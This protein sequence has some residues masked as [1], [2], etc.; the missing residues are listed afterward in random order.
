EQETQEY[1]PDRDVA[2]ET[3]QDHGAG[4][5]MPQEDSPVQREYGTEPETQTDPATDPYGA[6]TDPMEESDPQ[7]ASTYGEEV[8]TDL[9]EM[10][11]EELSGRTVTTV[12]GEE[13][14]EIGEI[15]YSATH[16]ERVATVEVGGFLGV[17]GKRIAIPLSELEPGEDDTSV[18]TSL[19]RESIEAQEEFD[20]AGFTLDE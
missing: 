6:E 9:S 5:E 1:D 8:G 4:M 2:T 20:E 17:G 15:G 11:A 12:T 13:I 18:Q 10:T 16:Q 14:G 7:S 19:S 3:E